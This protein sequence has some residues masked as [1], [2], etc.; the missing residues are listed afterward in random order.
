MGPKRTR[1]AI[2]IVRAAVATLGLASAVY[3]ADQA[4]SPPDGDDVSKVIT[5]QRIKEGALAKPGQD[6]EHQSEK[7]SPE[8]MVE[9]VGRYDAESKTAYEHAETTR[10]AAY[11]SRDIIRMTC[12]DDKLTQM[13]E[14][15]NLATPRVL[16]FARLRSDDLVMRQ[17][18]LVL[19]MARNRV[20]ELATEVES[21][22]GDALDV[23]SAGRIKEETPT[24]SVFDPT[25]PPS[26]TRDVDRPAEASPYR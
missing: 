24:D 6:P 10:I 20:M 18:F 8:Q 9:L 19:Q 1:P 21:C 14:V 2:W 5:S 13:K 3:A 11:R 22:M 12:I 23:V 26:P 17:H 16:A 15:L 4:G 7:L 25:R